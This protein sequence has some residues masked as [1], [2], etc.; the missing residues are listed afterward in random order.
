MTTSSTDSK[1]SKSPFENIPIEIKAAVEE[2]GGCTSKAPFALQV[3]GSSMEPEF[4]DGAVIIIDPNHP[5][6]HGTYVVADYDGETT[7]RQFVIRDNRK[8]LVA[9]NDNYPD[10]EITSE[11]TIRGV[12]TQRSRSRRHGYKKAKHYTYS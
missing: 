11:L 9:L 5:A 7:F 4:L 3:L 2:G 10:V 6:T 1:S 8:Y 12:I